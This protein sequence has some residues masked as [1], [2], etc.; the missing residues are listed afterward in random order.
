MKKKAFVFGWSGH[1][2]LGDEAFKKAFEYLWGDKVDFTF[3]SRVPPNINS[4]DICFVGGGSFLDQE[5]PK[6][7]EVEI[8]LG[9]IGIGLHSQIHLANVQALQKAKLVITRGDAVPDFIKDKSYVAS[10]LVFS[11]PFDQIDQSNTT[12]KSKSILVLGNEFLSPRRNGPLW[13]YT[14][15]Q[16]FLTEFSKVCDGWVEK[17]YAVNFYPMCTG[18]KFDDRYFAAHIASHMEKKVFVHFGSAI[19]SELIKHISESELIVSMR[20][21]GNIFSTVLG[22][23]FIGINSHDKMKTYFK[24]INSNNYLDYYG[25]TSSAFNECIETNKIEPSRLSEYAKKEKIRWQYLSD[26]VAEVF[27]M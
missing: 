27:A 19:E 21:H 17:G 26:I 13:K 24:N 4:F 15:F 14:S 2:N 8:P 9:F 3:G 11:R 23:P 5:I 12:S 25:F 18:D 16:W 22:K 1:N 20:F 6:L 7:N 10:D